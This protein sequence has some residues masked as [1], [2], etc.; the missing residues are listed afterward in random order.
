MDVSTLAQHIVVVELHMHIVPY[1]MYYRLW[2]TL[3]TL[4]WG[5]EAW[6]NAR[7]ELL[8]ESL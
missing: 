5:I 6:Q 7:G 3:G 2:R 1:S 8:F 4:C